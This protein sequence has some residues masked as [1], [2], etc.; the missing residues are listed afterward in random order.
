MTAFKKPLCGILAFILVFVF[1]AATPIS[2]FAEDEEVTISAK[3]IELN[4]ETEDGYEYIKVDAGSAVE[5]IKYVGNETEVKLP[6]K[7]GGLSVIAVGEGCFEGNKTVVSVKFNS[8]IV[9][10]KDRAFK[11]CTA[12]KEVTK[13]ESLTA[14]GASAFEGCS[15]LEEFEY[16]ESVT[17]VPEKCFAGCTALKEVKE[18]KNLKN[19]AMDAFEGTAWENAQPD[20]A[21]S[22]GRV[23]YGVKGQVKNI[24]IPKGVSLI[25]DYVFLGCDYI[26]TVTLGPDVEEI[27]LYAFQNCTN[28]K[29]VSFDVAIGVLEAGVFKGCSS[30]KVADFSESTLATIGYE[31]FA[32][33]TALEEIKIPET[34]SD[35]GDFAFANT[36]FK[37]IEFGKNINA[38][39]AN[40][41]VGNT[42]L[43][44]INVVDNN[45]EFSSIDGVLYNKKGSVLV[46]FPAGKTG[47]YELPQ[48]VEEIKD[49]AFKNAKISEVKLAEEP[50]LRY[51]GINAFE[52]SQIEK[53][54]ISSNVEKINS[55]TFKNAKKLAEVKFNDG[56]KYI[57]ASA[58]EN[59]VALKEIK[60]PDTLHDIANSAFKNAGLKSV[61][62]GDGVAK[63]NSEAFAG[64]KN[65][66]D[67]YIGKNVEK[68]GNGAFADCSKL[69]AV[70]LP[71]SLKAFSGNAFSGCSSLVKITVD[72]DSEFYKAVGSAIYSAD[73]KALVI[74]GNKNT[75]SLIVADGTEVIKANAFELAKNVAEISLPA[76]L[77]EIQG[78]ALDNTAWFKNANGLVYAGKILYKVKG[79][80][81]NVVVEEGTVAIADN[82]VNNPA[83]TT[84]LLPKTLVKIGDNAFAGSSVVSVAI[85]GNVKYIG[86]SAFKDIKALKTLTI[87]DG[88]ETIGAGAFEGCVALKEVAIPASVKLVPSDAFA[89]CKKLAKV[90]IAGAEKI[91]KYAFSGCE[92]LKT[93]TLPATLTELDPV[94][95]DGCTA[96]Q[97]IEV[98]EGNAFYKSLDG[99]V[100]VAN[101]EK[102]EDGSLVFETIALYPAGKKGEYKVPETVKN[103]ADRAFYNCDALTGIEFAEGFGNIGEEAFFDCD[104]ITTITMPESARDIGSYAFASCD[105][106]REFVVY[107]NLTDYADNAF[108]G[109]YYI[110]YD[111]VTIKVEDSSFSLLIIIAAIFVVIGVVWYLV[112]QKKQKKLEKEIQ[113]KIAKREA[114]EAAKAE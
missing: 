32:G 97:A 11:D 102:A 64:N 37:E 82:A 113:E 99:V 6:T 81:A 87:A 92:S 112:Y 76:T 55:N 54:E 45:K 53:F 108:D 12:L 26:E 86:V 78:N 83:V 24:E 57:A 77:S 90:E 110:N 71:A 40:S 103:I 34:L 93:I 27:G 44:T 101:E 109:C 80:I 84:V 69:V 106:L 13:T 62:L 88:V 20:G 47:T 89:G 10:V 96:L 56:L 66:T 29:E 38:V 19:V 9:T 91:G 95:F 7:L 35:I 49:Y 23:T 61:N 48:G 14:L 36:K 17:A 94:S 79:A 105:E 22:F 41:F 8:E 68:L 72:E 65:L 114:L 16:P 58:F 111:A 50:A 33:C 25:E 31:A 15:A 5:L 39:G 2:V 60:L 46:T 18:H 4:K 70:N 30:L 21:L 74:A 51:I 43:E 107:S 52:A 42:T 98:A 104:G 67:L 1:V 85:P 28:L 59:C 63:I 73:G 100:L 75:T 3:E